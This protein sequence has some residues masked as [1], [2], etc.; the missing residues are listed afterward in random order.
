MKGD[1]NVFEIT[2]GADKQVYFNNMCLV[3]KAFIGFNRI[4]NE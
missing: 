4:L 1:N 2:A 3:R